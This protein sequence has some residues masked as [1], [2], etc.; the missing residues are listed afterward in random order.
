MSASANGV[1]FGVTG[2]RRISLRIHDFSCRIWPFAARL[3]Q[4]NRACSPLPENRRRIEQP[5]V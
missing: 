5:L 2:W 1:R 4:I 3:C